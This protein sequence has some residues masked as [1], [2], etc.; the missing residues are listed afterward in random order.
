MHCISHEND[1][2]SIPMGRQEI[3]ITVEGKVQGVC[4]RRSTKNLAEQM[5]LTGW[6]KNLPGGEVEIC[7]IGTEDDAKHLMEKL[8]EKPEPHIV[9]YT[10]KSRPLNQEFQAFKIL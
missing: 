1:A 5:H 8:Q 9:S 7:I 2:W 10:I 6:V 3:H 4:F